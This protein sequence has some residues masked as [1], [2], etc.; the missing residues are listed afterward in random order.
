MAS[1]APREGVGSVPVIRSRACQDIKGVRA[2]VQSLSPHQC[3]QES[4]CHRPATDCPLPSRAV[5]TKAVYFGERASL[6]VGLVCKLDVEPCAMGHRVRG[7]NGAFHAHAPS[8][9]LWRPVMK[10]LSRVGANSNARGAVYTLLPARL[11]YTRPTP[12]ALTIRLLSSG[13][14]RTYHGSH[15]QCGLQ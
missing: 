12:Q 5:L 2:L 6:P 4:A 3:C 7:T 10:G 1:E 9:D 8:T 14:V 15:Q 13:Q 11:S